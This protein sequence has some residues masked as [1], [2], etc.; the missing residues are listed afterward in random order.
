MPK[1][2]NFF[3]VSTLRFHQR[4]LGN[5]QKG[6]KGGVRKSQKWFGVAHRG[7]CYIFYMG[8]GCFE[9]AIAGLRQFHRSKQAI[10][11]IEF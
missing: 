7:G 1:Y 4:A 3:I 11:Q 5:F 6:F 9:A 8:V 10:K 2:H